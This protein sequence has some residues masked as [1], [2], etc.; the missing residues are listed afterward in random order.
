LKGR[1]LE[2]GF[3]ALADASDLT[4]NENFT[5]CSKP[6]LTGSSAVQFPGTDNSHF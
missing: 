3:V 4:E 5:S 6:V 2:T 1:K